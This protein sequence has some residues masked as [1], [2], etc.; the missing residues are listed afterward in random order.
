M[1]NVNTLD[2]LLQIET[3]AAALVNDAQQEADRRMYQ[4]EEKNHAAYEEQYRAKVQMLE[5][6]NQKEIEKTKEKYL[7]T[8]DEY[9]REIS[10][11]NVNI[12]R[13]S[14]LLNEYLAVEL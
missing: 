10:N 1:E 9:R 13:F 8:L 5:A 3:K 7:E 4:S 6:I 2:Y 11:V 14:S 12:D